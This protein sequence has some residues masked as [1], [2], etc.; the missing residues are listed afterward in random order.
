M[1]LAQKETTSAAVKTNQNAERLERKI[2]MKRVLKNFG[3]GLAVAT[4]VA[5]TAFPAWN[6]NTSMVD[7]AARQKVEQVQM[8]KVASEK[9]QNQKVAA[10][11][12]YTTASEK[13]TVQM[14]QKYN[15]L[16]AASK[17]AADHGNLPKA[18]FELGQACHYSFKLNNQKMVSRA[19][20]Q[21][22]QIV[23][24]GMD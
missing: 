10:A 6:L 16:M 12:K 19:W 20:E 5:L 3:Y 11:E 9:T 17:K 18:A 7:Q 24:S 22:T 8:A 13:L 14:T 23:M 1:A 4:G 21:Y 15:D 2:K